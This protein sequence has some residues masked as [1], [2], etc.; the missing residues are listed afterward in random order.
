MMSGKTYAIGDLHGR[1]DILHAVIAAIEADSPE[2]GK[3]VVMG[4]FVDR[5]P[6]SRQIIDHLMTGP[7]PGWEW[8]VLQGN[9][10]DMML[11]CLAGRA[12]LRW[13]IGNGGGETLKSYGYRDGDPMQPLRIP[14]AHLEWL[15]G[16]PVY[17]Q[18]A[19][20]VY[21]HA[22]LD[23]DTPLEQQDKDTMQWALYVEDSAES[24]HFSKNQ[25]CYR[26]DLYVVHGHH[27]FANGPKIRK[28]RANFDTFAWYTGRQA[29]GVFETDQPGAPIDI[30]WAECSPH[31]KGR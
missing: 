17:H 15:L 13:W 30:L 6:H 5:G 24:G 7:P 18:E 3:L 22:G 23:P 21:V 19:D 4:D 29:I 12:P 31:E 14:D 28:Q 8:V 26:P 27:Q 10:E 11:H 20:R 2:G 25:L 1:C 9:H 16:L